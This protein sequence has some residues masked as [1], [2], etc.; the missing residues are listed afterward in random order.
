VLHG[1]VLDADEKPVKNAMVEANLEHFTQNDHWLGDDGTDDAGRFTLKNCLADRAL[2]ISVR[3][4][5][6]FP[7]C[8]LRN[9]IPGPDELVIRLPK[10][11]WVHI[12]GRILDPEGK[13]L[14]SVHATALMTGANGSPVETADPCTGEFRWGPYPPGEY[15]LRLHADGYMDI[16]LPARVLAADEVWDVGT[17]R[18]QKGGTLLVNVLPSMGVPPPHKL[19]LTILDSSNTIVDSNGVRAEE[20]NV[21]DGL[22]RSGLLRPGSYHLQVGGEHFASYLQAFDVRAGAETV[23]DVSLQPGIGAEVECILP[24]NDAVEGLQR[25]VQIVITDRSGV[26]VLHGIALPR[27]GSAKLPVC[28]LPG[29]YR[30]EATRGELRAS[31]SLTLGPGSAAASVALRLTRE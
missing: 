13:A 11:A 15:Q 19:T 20:V 16:S 22:G 4:T 31:A 3:R 10:E 28:L 2:K 21:E 1:L 26:I 25:L 17:L 27:E 18:F 30:I 5:S 12:Q 24:P 8:V 7:E 9:V 6:T 29:D 23:I 14:P